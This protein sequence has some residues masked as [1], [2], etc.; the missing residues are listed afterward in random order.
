MSDLTDT[1]KLFKFQNLPRDE[2]L[3]FVLIP[4]KP[5]YLELFEKLIKPT[6]TG[7]KKKLKCIK[8][9]DPKTNNAIIKD[10]VEN[11]HKSRFV[12]ADITEKNSNVMYEVGVADAIFREVILINN[13]KAREKQDYPFDI[14]H[15]RILNYV[16]T[17]TGGEEFRKSLGEMVDYALNKTYSEFHEKPERQIEKIE[18]EK[19]DELLHHSRVQFAMRARRIEWFTYHAIGFLSRFAKFHNTILKE[20]EEL[21]VRFSA[22]KFVSLKNRCANRIPSPEY[23]KIFILEELENTKNFIG[24]AWLVNKFP[25][26]LKSIGL[27]NT[28]T[29]VSTIDNMVFEYK[30]DGI[31]EGI[32]FDLERLNF[33]ISTMQD[34]RT[35]V[36]L[37]IINLDKT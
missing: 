8:A 31:I 1:A 22:R 11:I 2:N 10:I 15:R 5:K 37:P 13:R 25:D 35:E 3:V 17:I 21:K 24:N 7:R 9:N 34:E 12:I 26:E 29:Y 18:I 4:F 28:L 27:G 32:N 33:Y 19:M 16:D 6:V 36:G 23:M 20:L 14:K 30:Y